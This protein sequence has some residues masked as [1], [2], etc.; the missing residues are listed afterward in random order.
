MYVAVYDTFHDLHGTLR[1]RLLEGVALRL[2]G[3]E[4]LA[5]AELPLWADLKYLHMHS[6]LHGQRFGLHHSHWLFGLPFGLST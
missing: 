3:A 5:V 1:A 2:A 4:L 6:T